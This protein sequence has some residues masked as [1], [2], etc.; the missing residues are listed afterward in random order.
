MTRVSSLSSTPVSV[1]EPPA[2]AAMIR[3]RLV[4]LLEPGTC[5]TPW[6]GGPIQGS[7]VISV[8]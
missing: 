1:L 6:G 2:I 5:T 7:I 8:G 3:A 4:R